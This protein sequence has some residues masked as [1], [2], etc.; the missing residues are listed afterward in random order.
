M[1]TTHTTRISQPVALWKEPYWAPCSEGELKCLEL[2]SCRVLRHATSGLLTLTQL[3]S[4]LD[5]PLPVCAACHAAITGQDSRPSGAFAGTL[6]ITLS[7]RF[8]LESQTA[9]SGT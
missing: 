2:A 7:C 9:P 4:S 3:P 1:P 6:E 8:Q 5:W